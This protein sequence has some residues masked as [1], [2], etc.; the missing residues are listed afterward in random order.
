MGVVKRLTDFIFFAARIRVDVIQILKDHSF[1]LPQQV[2]IGDHQESR[3]GKVDR[4]EIGTEGICFT[5]THETQLP[6]DMYIYTL[7]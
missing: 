4:K 1:E 5:W 2:N 6:H 3:N 7:V